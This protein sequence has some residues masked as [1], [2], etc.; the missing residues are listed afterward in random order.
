[1][2]YGR[3]HKRKLKFRNRE[4]ARLDH[5]D[6]VSILHFLAPETAE[7]TADSM[8]LARI[9]SLWPKLVGD[10]LANHTQPFAFA[11]GKLTV[12]CDHNTFAQQLHML[13]HVIEKKICS[14]LDFQSIRIKVSTQKLIKWAPIIPANMTEEAKPLS[15]EAQKNIKKKEELFAPLIN[16]LK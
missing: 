4:R 3:I 14:E 12:H 13:T 10:I 5:N 6:W 15:A 16:S 7:K 1:V 2:S 8:T 9:R 11:Y